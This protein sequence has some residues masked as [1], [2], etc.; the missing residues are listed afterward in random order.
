MPLVWIKDW[1]IKFKVTRGEKVKIKPQQA[2]LHSCCPSLTGRRAVWGRHGG[3]RS[4]ERP[5][6]PWWLFAQSDGLQ[7]ARLL[8]P[9]DSPGKNTGMGCRSL[10]QGIFPTQESNP[11]LL[12][13]RQIL[14]WLSYKGNAIGWS[15]ITGWE[16]PAYMQK[17]QEGIFMD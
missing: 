15:K 12:H 17:C 5:W 7:P 14:Y 11:G 4:G 9:W 6:W 13:C 8:R 3:D 10:L 16:S 1:A 2:A